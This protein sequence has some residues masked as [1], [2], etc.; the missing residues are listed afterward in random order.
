MEKKLSEEEFHLCFVS[1]FFKSFLLFKKSFKCDKVFDFDKIPKQFITYILL[2]NRFFIFQPSPALLEEKA[3][4]CVI[5]NVIIILV[6]G[7]F[8]HFHY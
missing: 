8:G 1:I 2:G 4:I 6:L 3:L 5:I 7:W